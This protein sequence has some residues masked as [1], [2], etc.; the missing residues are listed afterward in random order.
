MIT[1]ADQVVAE[2][3]TLHR[4]FES[5]FRGDSASLDRVEQALA[6]DFQLISPRGDVVARNTILDDL[7]AARGSRQVAIRIEEP[8]LLWADG[9]TVV[10]AYEEWHDHADYSTV[11][12]STALFAINDA[13]PGGLLW[14]L[15]HETFRIPP[16]SWQLP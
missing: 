6:D 5:W 16:P 10:A 12:Q 9:N 4:E 3:V 7:S 13:A 15:V 11:R 8:Q 14:R 1:G 2:I